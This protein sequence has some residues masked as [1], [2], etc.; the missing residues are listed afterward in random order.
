ML[1]KENGHN[2][3]NNDICWFWDHNEFMNYGEWLLFVKGI[4]YSM[5]YELISNQNNHEV[6]LDMCV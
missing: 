1:A 4:N 2:Y 6:Q 5:M 3:L